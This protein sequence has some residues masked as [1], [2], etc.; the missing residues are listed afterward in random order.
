MQAEAFDFVVIGCGPAGEKAAAQAAYFG[1]RVAVIERETMLGGAMVG[2]VVTT[3]TFREAAMYV[4]GYHRRE[5]YGVA[6]EL[7]APDAVA[8]VHG[9]AVEVAAVMHDAVAEN[10]VRH[11]IELVTGSATLLG[12]GLVG[13]TGRDG[14]VRRLEAPAILVATGSRPY[15][16]PGI[17]FGDP[18]IFDADA[19]R[20][21]DAPAASVAVLGGGVVGCEYASMLRALG[22]DVT[23]VHTG[24]TLLPFLDHDASAHL[25]ACFVANGID[26]VSGAGRPTV[27]RGGGG[28]VVALPGGGGELRPAKVVV[29]LGRSGNTEGL[30]LEEAGVATDERGRI[31]V[32]ERFETSVPGVFAA[33]DVIGPPALASVGMEQGRVAACHACAIPFKESVDPVAPYGVFTIPEAAMVGLTER[34]ARARYHDVEIGAT[35]FARNARSV[36]AGSTDGLVKLVFRRGDLRLLGVHIVGDAACELIHYGQAV[37]HFGGGIDHFISSTFNVPTASEA[38]KYAAYDGLGRVAG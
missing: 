9:R 16:P 10:L 38:Y 29:A 12:G 27:G 21:L 34:D 1:R 8:R 17:D 11:G 15:H 4:T 37:L 31:V 36:I 2:S 24:S 32:D 19:A 14:A 35:P 5:V 13:V 25:G 6:P 23:L 7:E 3:K 28:L 20:E 33:G 30:G 22:A 26:V 18:D